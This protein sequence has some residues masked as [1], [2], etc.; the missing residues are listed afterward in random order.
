MNFKEALNAE[1]YAAVSAPDGPALV[2]A[3]AGTGKTRTLIYR[4]AWLVTERGVEPWEVLLL[5]FTN[6]AASEMLSRAE[7]LVQRRFNSGFSGTFHSFANRLLRQ[8]ADRVGFGKDFSILDADDAKK[9]LRNCADELGMDKKM[10]PKPDVL[11]SLFG[12]VSGRQGD[13]RAAVEERFEHAE[14]EVTDILKV[15][16]LYTE[17]KRSTNTMDFDAGEILS[18]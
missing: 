1:Q 13:L 8:H 17:K 6:K 11:L 3:A 16:A 12:V 5:T 14:V 15:Q 7:E 9:L 18:G 4:L 10:F 2:V